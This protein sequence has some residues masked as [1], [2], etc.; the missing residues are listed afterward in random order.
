LLLVAKKMQ[1]RKTAM[2]TGTT[3]NGEEICMLR[4]L[5]AAYR[6]A[7]GMGGLEAQLA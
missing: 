3:K 7:G 4:R 1:A 2:I 5:L 6:V